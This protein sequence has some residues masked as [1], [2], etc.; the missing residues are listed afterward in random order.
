MKK[1]RSV[2]FNFF[3]KHAA[4][5]CLILKFDLMCCRWPSSALASDLPAR[6]CV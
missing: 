3:E 4:F 5:D 6:P 1:S 2:F